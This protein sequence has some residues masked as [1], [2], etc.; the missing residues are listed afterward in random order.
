M[1]RLLDVI[2][3]GAP[4]PAAPK[5]FDETS[6]DGLIRLVLEPGGTCTI[7]IDHFGAEAEDGIAHVEATIKILYNQA[8]KKLTNP[9]PSSEQERTL[10]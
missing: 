9:A 8:T 10:E 6:S 4:A 5:R 3:Q 1:R 2:A 7:D